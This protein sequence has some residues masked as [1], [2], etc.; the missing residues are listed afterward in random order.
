MKIKPIMKSE[1]FKRKVS[2]SLFAVASVALLCLLILWIASPVSAQKKTAAP[3]LPKAFATAQEGAEA[4]VAAAEKFDGVAFKEILGP[5][6]DDIIYTGEPA[7]DR[8][9]ATEFAAQARKK[10]SVSVDPKTRRRAFMQIGDSNWTFPVPLV[11]VGA[12][13]QFDVNAG[14]QEVLYRRIGRNEMNT[15]QICRGYVEAQHEYALSKH[16]DSKV[17]QYAQRIIS[18]RGKHDG[19]A[20]WNAD[21]TWG[22]TIGETAARALEQSYTG[23]RAPF[24]GYYF[25]ILKGQGPAAPLGKIDFVVKGAMIGGFALIAYPANYRV[26]GIKTFMISHDGVLYEKD[27]GPN[28]LKIVEKIERFNPDKTWLPVLEDEKSEP[29][30]VGGNIY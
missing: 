8:E 20:W 24:H 14:R 26:T 3:N 2:Q 30:N 23:A 15:I 11:K 28:T 16:D 17:N 18:S 9:N 4:L 7:L 10:L 25:K 6:S 13:W 12:K 21:G 22:G 19:L 27:F 29:S 1:F 5:N